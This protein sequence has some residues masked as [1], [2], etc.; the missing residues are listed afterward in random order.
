V[1]T[2]FIV[3]P[4]DNKN[5]TRV[6]INTQSPTSPGLQGFME[7][8]FQPMITRSI[9]EKEIKLLAEYVRRGN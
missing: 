8:L 2:T 6:T 3:E 7:K 1:I 4:L 9:Y 5:E